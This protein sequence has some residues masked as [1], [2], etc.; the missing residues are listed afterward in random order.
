M[1]PSLR[2]AFAG[3]DAP[4]S[5]NE[6]RDSSAKD[7]APP[8]RE[9][10]QHNVR[11][12]FERAKEAEGL[13]TVDFDAE[14]FQLAEQFAG[15]TL[16]RVSSTAKSSPWHNP[17][18]A[19]QKMRET[20][21]GYYVVNGG[22]MADLEGGGRRRRR[23]RRDLQGEHQAQVISHCTV[24]CVG[25]SKKTRSVLFVWCACVT[26]RFT[27]K[28]RLDTWEDGQEEDKHERPVDRE[29]YCSG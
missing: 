13:A 17:T 3:T 19:A 18:Y 11:L 6:P 7:D 12:K 29:G 9:L 22:H 25:F 8:P 10:T 21:L 20:H 1:N 28:G 16:G 15:N 24:P 5:P 27:K 2:K 4:V 14:Q 26:R 23:G